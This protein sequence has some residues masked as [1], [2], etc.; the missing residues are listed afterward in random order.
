M[1][2]LSLPFV[3]IAAG[4]AGGT[5][6]AQASA[7]P[8]LRQP[9][10]YAVVIGISQYR[11]EVIPKV[12]YAVKDAEAIAK[13][14]EQQAGIPKTHIRLLTEAKATSAD[15]RTIGKW[16]E[17]RVKPDSTVYIYYAGHGTPNPKTGDVYVVPW[18]GH[19]DYPDGLYPLND[20]YKTLNTLPAK[21]IVVLL[22]AC[23]S[24]AQ[25][26]SVLAK[27]AR[28]MV[29]S[30]ENPLLASGKVIV[31]A[32][33]TGNQISS[34]YD[35]AGHGLFTHAVLTG[36]QGGAD[37]DKNGLVTLKELY[38]YVKQQ[39]AETAVEELNR[40]QTPVLLPGEEALGPRGT[41]PVA[42]VSA[43]GPVPAPGSGKPSVSLSQAERELKALE[44]QERQVE[45]QARHADVQ[46]QIAEKKRQIEEKKKKLEVASLPTPSLPRQMGREIEGKDGAKMVLVSEGEFAYGPNNERKSLPAFYLDKYEV[47]TAQYAKF[48]ADTGRKEPRYWQ[49]SV[50]VSNGQKPVVGV[51]WNDADAYCRHYG[52]RLPTEQEWEKA[53]RGTDGRTYPW[54][55]EEPTSRHANF[56]RGS[57][58]QN[59]G[60]LVN[61]GSLEA[62]K[63]P[64][65]IY[66]L[67]GNVW[68]WTSSDYDN[69]GQYKVDRGGSWNGT[70][71]FLRSSLRDNVY[72]SIRL[73]YRGF[74]CAQDAR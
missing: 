13:M 23:F 67:A 73:S 62:G 58:F 1:R 25:G 53:A 26:R 2:R 16:L 42:M 55:N 43:G 70:A 3:L 63:S 18:D 19:P 22:D 5:L 54:G 45:E 28:P 29:V 51:D 35:K 39:V 30:V 60:V 17:L 8:D 14:L 66:D 48:M 56:G 31:L 15:L 12:A 24:G 65:G 59:Y 69:S 68:E 38:P 72:P 61:V 57:D 20:L 7:A 9:N 11:E 10:A 64:Y 21:D 34:D 33:A 27:G 32:A 74:R 71:D 46:R 50:P 47:T 40:E 44:E 41:L 49:T 6:P 4:L 52:K 37:Q 36:L